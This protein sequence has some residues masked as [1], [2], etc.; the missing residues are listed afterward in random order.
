[1]QSVAGECTK[2]SSLPANLPAVDSLCCC[3]NVSRQWPGEQQLQSRQQGS[4]VDLH[5]CSLSK[6]ACELLGVSA[7]LAKYRLSITNSLAISGLCALTVCT[8]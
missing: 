2:Q 3:C 1:M 6:A 4:I 8:S 7:C 5:S